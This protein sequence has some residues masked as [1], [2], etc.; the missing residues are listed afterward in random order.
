MTNRQPKGTP[1]GGQFAEGRK[2]DGAD[3]MPPIVVDEPVDTIVPQ[4]NSVPNI[5]AVV[6]AIADGC[7]SGLEIGEAVGMSGRQGEYYPNAAHTLGLAERSYGMDGSGWQLSP[8][9]AAFVGLDAE[10]RADYICDAIDEIDWVNTYV[11]NGPEA[12]RDEWKSEG[13]LGDETIKRRLATIGAWVTFRTDSRDEQVK[14]I[15]E[16]MT[17]TRERTPDIIARAQDRART[18]AKNDKKINAR[19]CPRCHLVVAP[20]VPECENCGAAVA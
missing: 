9:G 14:L 5:S 2:P 10:G 1:I 7:Y 15:S 17:G 16:A 12:L 13:K 20:S 18:R 4:A 6:D 19:K 3:I 11:N 8:T